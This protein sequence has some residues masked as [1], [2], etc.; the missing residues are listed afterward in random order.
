MIGFTIIALSILAWAGLDAPAEFC[1]AAA[2]L[3]AAVGVYEASLAGKR[4]SHD[5]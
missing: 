4:S 5:G 3:G 1:L 2:L